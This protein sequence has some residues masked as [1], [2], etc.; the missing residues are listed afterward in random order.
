M[1]ICI[2]ARVVCLIPLEDGAMHI[3]CKRDISAIPQH[4]S[5]NKE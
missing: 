4:H 5:L 1:K 3:E 2:D